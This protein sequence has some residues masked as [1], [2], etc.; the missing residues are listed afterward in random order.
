MMEGFLFLAGI[1]VG[2]TGFGIISIQALQKWIN[3]GDLMCSPTMRCQ[4]P[5]LCRRSR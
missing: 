2:V 1:I 4:C 3:D 5:N